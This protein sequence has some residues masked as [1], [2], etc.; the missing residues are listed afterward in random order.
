[1]LRAPFGN[2][3]YAHNTSRDDSFMQRK[4]VEKCDD[5][6][7]SAAYNER[8][9]INYLE[10]NI[11][12]PPDIATDPVKLYVKHRR[13]FVMSLLILLAVDM[14]CSVVGIYNK[15][16]EIDSLTETKKFKQT[17]KFLDTFL[18]VIFSI[19][20]IVYLLLGISGFVA[21]YTNKS[22]LYNLHSAM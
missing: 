19:D 13:F 11:D 9:L 5:S 12:F 2:M 20:I 15:E 8:R 22:R 16:D 1:M 3:W 6:R 17:Q 10:G 21:Y 4:S 14:M 7:N 18:Q